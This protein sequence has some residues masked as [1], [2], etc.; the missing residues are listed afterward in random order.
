MGGYTSGRISVKNRYEAIEN[1]NHGVVIG[2][3]RKSL[4]SW[5][6]PIKINLFIWLMV[7]N[8]ILTWEILQCRG[9]LGLG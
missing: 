2:G 6:C 7:E 8:K 4:W 5:E 3:W 9:F 1:K